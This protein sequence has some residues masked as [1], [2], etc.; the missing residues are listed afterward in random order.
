[1]GP[2]ISILNPG[3]SK[4][5]LDHVI[6]TLNS[7]TERVPVPLDAS[8]WE[9]RSQD[10]TERQQELRHLIDEWERSGRNLLKLFKR[11][12]YLE[13]SC[14]EGK[15]Y[16]GPTRDGVAQLA[17]L[18]VL[19]GRHVSPQKYGALTLF[20]QFLVNPLSLKLGGPC[21]RCD[22]FYIKSDP[23]NKA[24]CSRTC[25]KE[26]TARAST[27]RRRKEEDD[28]KVLK[29]QLAIEQLMQKGPFGKDW[30]KRVATKMHSGVTEKW[31][32]RA[33]NMGKLERPP[34]Y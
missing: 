5:Q 3:Y 28:G 33:L 7:S 11:N 1:M 14:T 15:T 4:L 26:N 32:T 21:K 13:E 18:P 6:R 12:P 22:R 8:N 29:A 17:W 34:G 31:V 23:R 30:K 10:I 16:L 2:N 25:G 20:T 27:K 9:W 19:K 24:Y